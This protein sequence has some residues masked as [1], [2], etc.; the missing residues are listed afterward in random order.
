MMWEMHTMHN[1]HDGQHQESFE[2]ERNRS[3]GIEMGMPAPYAMNEMPSPPSNPPP[4]IAG[5]SQDLHAWSIY[6][7]VIDM[8]S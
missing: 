3:G 5:T 8:H 2:D 7:Q 6:R 1:N 4:P